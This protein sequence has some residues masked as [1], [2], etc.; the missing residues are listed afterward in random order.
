MAIRWMLLCATL[1][2]IACSNPKDA[3][4]PNDPNRWD[5]DLRSTMERLPLDE[6]Q[7]AVSYLARAKQTAALSGQSIREGVTLGQAIQEQREYERADAAQQME[8]RV[9]QLQRDRERQELE[10]RAAAIVSVIAVN[11]VVTPGQVGTGGRPDQANLKFELRNN[12]DQ[13][14]V[15]LVGTVRLS[16]SFPGDLTRLALDYPEPIAP[17]TTVPWEASV[18]LSPFAN[19]DQRLR[20]V[21]LI[22]MKVTFTPERVELADGTKVGSAA[23]ST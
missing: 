4:I 23:G 15:G 12:G 6:R 22:N 5:E 10:R 7:L 9:Q 20:N 2:L 14:I 8:A 13:A 1:L 19:T 3:R 17:R 16:D 21:D 11:K 18:P